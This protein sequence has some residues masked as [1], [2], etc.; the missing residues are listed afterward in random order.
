MIDI[1]IMWGDTRLGDVTLREYDKPPEKTLSG[2]TLS[3]SYCVRIGP[4]HS[5][6]NTSKAGRLCRASEIL[7]AAADELDKE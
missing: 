2:R 5:D 7:R 1:E 4:P 3:E 6:V